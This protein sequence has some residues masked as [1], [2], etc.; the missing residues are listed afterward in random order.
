MTLNLLDSFGNVVTST[1]NLDTFA[2]A[3]LVKDDTMGATNLDLLLGPGGLSNPYKFS[4][5]APTVA[6]HY[7]AR[8]PIGSKIITTQAIIT[9]IPGDPV[10]AKF[11][12]TGPGGLEAR[13]G[14]NFT[15]FITARDLYNNIWQGDGTKLGV[16]ITAG[17]FRVD[18]ADQ[19]ITP[20]ALRG[21]RLTFK[22]PPTTGPCT[23][24]VKGFA[25]DFTSTVMNMR[26]VA[27]ELRQVA[28]EELRQGVVNQL[29]SFFLVAQDAGGF[30]RDDPSLPPDRFYIRLCKNVT[31]G[32]ATVNDRHTSGGRY[33]VTWGA[34]STGEYQVQFWSPSGLPSPLT[35]L[36]VVS[37]AGTS[38]V[39][40]YPRCNGVPPTVATCPQY[41]G[42]VAGQVAS[43]N[44][45]SN[46][47]PPGAP[48]TSISTGGN[49][50]AISI[51]GGRIISLIDQGDGT[52][53]V[54]Y[55]ATS[56]P[57]AL[58]VNNGVPST[59]PLTITP[60][61]T[62][63]FRCTFQLDAA[64]VPVLAAGSSIT[65]KFTANDA[66]GN[67][68]DYSQYPPESDKFMLVARNK[69]TGEMTVAAVS[70]SGAGVGSISTNL[71][72][73]WTGT[74]NLQAYL[75][76]V[77]IQL[78]GADGKVPG[79]SGFRVTPGPPDIGSMV[80]PP[81]SMQLTT[82]AGASGTLMLYSI[83]D[84]YGNPIPKS[85]L[86]CSAKVIDERGYDPPMTC[87]IGDNYITFT[88]A[89][90]S[91]AGSNYTFLY[92]V[93]S[94]GGEVDLSNPL[95]IAPTDPW[96]PSCSVLTPSPVITQVGSKTV[97]T[98][99][100]KDKFGNLCT[101]D[102]SGQFIVSVGKVGGL[103]NSPI[104]AASTVQSNVTGQTLA[105]FYLKQ[106]GN[107]TASVRFNDMGD[108]MIGG[109]ITIISSPADTSVNLTFAYLASSPRKLV[110]DTLPAR[111]VAGD[112]N[113]VKVVGVDVNGN[114]QDRA[115]CSSSNLPTITLSTDDVGFDGQGGGVAPLVTS[116]IAAL[117]SSDPGCVFIFNFTATA[118]Y[119]TSSPLMPANY[120]LRIQWTGGATSTPS[121]IA[122][123]PFNLQVDPGTL[124]IPSSVVQL[125]ARAAGVTGLST[126]FLLSTRDRF[127]NQP[128]YN[129]TLNVSAVVAPAGSFKVSKRRLLEL[130]DP[131]I[132]NSSNAETVQALDFWGDFESVPLMTPVVTNNLDTTYSISFTVIKS[133]AYDILIYMNGM[134]L[135]PNP[136]TPPTISS[137]IVVPG[138]PDITRLKPLGLGISDDKMVPV[139][140]TLNFSINL[141]DNF[142]NPV[143]M[144]GKADL[145]NKYI[146]GISAQSVIN[147]QRAIGNN[148]ISL[149][150]VNLTGGTFSTANGVI[151]YSC[152]PTVAGLMNIA[153]AYTDATSSKVVRSV[154]GPFHATIVP[155][156]GS[157]PALFSVFGPGVMA[158]L[159]CED[160]DTCAMN[161]MYVL[162]R[163]TYNNTLY[164][165][166]FLC[167]SFSLSGWNASIMLSYSGK[168]AFDNYCAISYKVLP[169]NTTR[170]V[171]FNVSYNTGSSQ[172]LIPALRQWTTVDQ[173][174]YSFTVPVLTD[175]QDPEPNNCLA[176]GDLGGM[177][178]AGDAGHIIVQLVDS[179]GLAIQTSLSS[180]GDYVR[181]VIT[182]VNSND[183]NYNPPLAPTVS[184]TDNGDGTFSLEYDTAK[185]GNF[186]ILIMVGL[187]DKPLGGKT[188]GYPLQVILLTPS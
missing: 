12:V 139:G 128:F 28:V 24:S 53:T 6:G 72:L 121:D 26:I 56:I 55:M 45:S 73:I 105:Y 150:P 66:M 119:K 39:M 20:D 31:C 38:K 79:S 59:I 143:N 30:R 122:G 82:T 76:E 57:A 171:N 62:A 174:G 159:E 151:V 14:T 179:N 98:I 104:I 11:G 41:Y 71:T 158:A 93:I 96:P 142:G 60:G 127:G 140:S 188:D 94:P 52:Y 148:T 46:N 170:N 181:L 61:L 138:I 124:D 85:L 16:S 186:T 175:T 109:P 83:N 169:V 144:V 65:G 70:F 87:A 42:A 176:F 156:G 75:N 184:S 80:Y 29:S 136:S 110:T 97:L 91:T 131:K 123:S 22:T 132:L 99:L 23:I 125:Q 102:R 166:K 48:P 58:N 173:S 118:V 116:P 117:S 115:K 111:V 164:P 19:S 177:M 178:M 25:S 134:I 152:T 114:L 90:L 63:A 185:S 10:G 1:T 133:A 67:Q 145:L 21:F 149:S 95:F 17:N 7:Y 137:Y 9:V 33:R 106:S 103:P 2:G 86:N 154:L 40:Y 77:P 92:S 126:T 172:L 35:N 141:C 64:L 147:I 130:G 108:P 112:S 32:R 18:P 183:P 13:P 37:S 50:P 68:Q 163:D 129:Q 168:P 187:T 36:T 69:D 49:L 27:G 153:L 167:A 8:I 43:F 100:C 113:V 155:N 81:D 135:Q 157:N 15:M 84:I 47:E 51:T 182:P 160:K 44:L 180:G 88:Y 5:A 34:P 165:D 120:N 146:T 89:N 4:F 3:V 162:I 78:L 101:G 107:F 74:Y 161:T 54:S